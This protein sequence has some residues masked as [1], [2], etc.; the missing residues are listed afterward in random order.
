MDIMPAGALPSWQQAGDERETE[1]KSGAVSKR[2]SVM[3]LL[4]SVAVIG[5]V[6]A[7]GRCPPGMFPTGGGGAGWEGCAP[8][9]PGE[10]DEEWNAA[11]PW[12]PMTPQEQAEYD[13]YLK[14]GAEARHRL[15]D[16]AWEYR[17]GHGQQGQAMCEARFSKMGESIALRAT[18]GPGGVAML[19]FRG[20]KVPHPRQPKP[21]KVTLVQG[22]GAGQAVSA[23]SYKQRDLGG[24]YDGALSFT[25]PSVEALLASM[26]DTQPFT[27]KDGGKTL[28]D[29]QWHHGREA[30]EA[31]SQCLHGR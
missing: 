28:V 15:T 26:E 31:L 3:L 1:M 6:R 2:V 10:S 17:R 30:R 16:G 20:K 21:I 8:M 29:L 14:E 11:P 25:V 4:C 22:S 27:V 13:Q 7:E 9:G 18:P 5:T 23:Y 19:T 12:R 24:Y